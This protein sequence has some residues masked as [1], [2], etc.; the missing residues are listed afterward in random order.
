MSA[1]DIECLVVQMDSI[2]KHFRS[3]WLKKIHLKSAF[4]CQ[5]HSHDETKG[6][7]TKTWL[8]GR[9]GFLP[10]DPEVRF[11]LYTQERT[12]LLSQHHSDKQATCV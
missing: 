5:D 7:L 12:H 4:R 10:S 2:Q 3:V 9:T 11:T 6:K 8:G 1:G